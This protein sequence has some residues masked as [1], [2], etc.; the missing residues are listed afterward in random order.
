LAARPLNEAERRASGL[1]DGLLVEKV[2]GPAAQAGI[3]PGDI[4]LL[5]K[6]TPTGDEMRAVFGTSY[7]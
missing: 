5:L 4:I 1:A 2:G 7:C 6:T 3:E